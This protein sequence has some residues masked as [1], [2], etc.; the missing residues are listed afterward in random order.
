MNK[1]FKLSYLIILSFFISCGSDDDGGPTGGGPTGPGLPEASASYTI[2]LTTN[3]NQTDNPQDYPTNA[4][5][6]TIVAIAHAPEVSVYSLGQLASD[7]MA[8]YAESG[9]V[10]GLAAFIS[11]SLGEE[12]DGLFSITTAGMVGPESSA[13][14]SVTV[15]PT[16]TRITVLARLNPSPDWFLGVSSFNVVNGDELIDLEEMEL[17]PI[18]AGVIL[19]DTYEANDGDENAAISI[20]DGAPFGNGNPLTEPLA[21]LVIERDN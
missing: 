6:G 17:R 10:D 2:E 11:T 4:S 9:D 16:R 7:G 3:F 15:T 18:D 21:N 13:S 14:T 19:G 12:G 5:F 20:Y 8:L 1:L